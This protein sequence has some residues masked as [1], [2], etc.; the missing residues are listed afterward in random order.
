MSFFSRKTRLATGGRS[1]RRTFR[2]HLEKLED[3][4]VPAIVTGDFGFA[5]GFDSNLGENG[6][7]VATDGA[8]VYVTGYFG[9]TVDFD[10]GAG[11]ANLSVYGSAD[12]MVAKYSSTTGALVW[13]G[14]FARGSVT[15]GEAIAVDRSEERRVGKECRL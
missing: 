4:T 11:V 15:S 9:G 13:A 8:Y 7:A 1:P 10:P 12:A 2:P 14:Q 5:L 6:R 3:R